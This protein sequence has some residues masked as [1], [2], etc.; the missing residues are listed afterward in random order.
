MDNQPVGWEVLTDMTVNLTQREAIMLVEAHETLQALH[1]RAY[2]TLHDTLDSAA[3]RPAHAQYEAALVGELR[4]LSAHAA[5]T[6]HDLLLLLDIRMNVETARVARG[7]IMEGVGGPVVVCDRH[8]ERL[9]VGTIVSDDEA[10]W[11]TVI[12]VTEPDGDTL[13]DGTP[14]G[15]PVYVEVQYPDSEST[16]PCSQIGGQWVCHDVQALVREEA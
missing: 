12:R 2:D 15:L 16:W 6:L 4:A 5:A 11:G 1:Q 13:A 8:G 10:G 3:H 14:F 7:R 9:E